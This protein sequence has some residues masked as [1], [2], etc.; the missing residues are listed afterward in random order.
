VLDALPSAVASLGAT[1][2]AEVVGSLQ[3]KRN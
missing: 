2:V 3:L 1:S